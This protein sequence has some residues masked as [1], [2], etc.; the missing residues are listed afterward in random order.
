ML[1]KTKQKQLINSNLLIFYE[2]G[3]VKTERH[4]QPSLSLST[5]RC[6]LLLS[7]HYSVGGGTHSS[8]YTYT[9]TWKRRNTSTVRLKEE[10]KDRHTFISE[11]KRQKIIEN[12]CNTSWS[13]LAEQADLSSLRKKHIDPGESK[14]KR[15]EKKNVFSKT[16]EA[17]LSL[18]LNLDAKELRR[19]ELHCEMSKW[20]LTEQLGQ[21][22]F[23]HLEYTHT[24]G[25]CF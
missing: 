15:V 13:R 25:F 9:F 12:Q 18:L 21:T 6:V 14:I 23:R 1:L 24:R 7:A 2:L 10:R 19:D 11:I 4:C 3:G 16:D 5:V 8:F 17:F 22:R 20:D